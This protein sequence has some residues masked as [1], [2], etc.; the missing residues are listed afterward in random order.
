MSSI[1][2]C[3]RILLW[4][5]FCFIMFVEAQDT[6]RDTQLPVLI[7]PPNQIRNRGSPGCGVIDYFIKVVNATTIHFDTQLDIIG[8]H[9]IS[10]SSMENI[11]SFTLGE[12]AEDSITLTAEYNRKNTTTCTFNFTLTDEYIPQPSRLS[13]PDDQTETRTC[14][15]SDYMFYFEDL[16]LENATINGQTTQI[17]QPIFIGYGKTKLEYIAMDAFGKNHRCSSSVTIKPAIVEFTTGRDNCDA[18]AVCT[19]TEGSFACKCNTGYTGDGRTCTASSEP[20]TESNTKATVTPRVTTT[21]S[22]RERPTTIAIR[23]V[24]TQGVGTAT[25]TMETTRTTAKTRISSTGSTEAMKTTDTTVTTRISSTGSTETTEMTRAAAT[26]RI[27]S[28]EYVGKI[29]DWWVPVQ[30]GLCG[31]VVIMFVIGIIVRFVR[32]KNLANHDGNL[33]M[34]EQ[35]IYIEN[36][37]ET[38]SYSEPL[39]PATYPMT[40]NPIH[41][42]LGTHGDSIPSHPPPSPPT[43]R[44]SPNPGSSLRNHDYEEPHQEP[45]SPPRSPQPQPAANIES[46]FSQMALTGNFTINVENV[47]INTNNQIISYY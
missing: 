16:D 3:N 40:M 21:Q 15:E 38:H 17:I 34:P 11:T 28:T 1:P 7:C 30:I 24:S 22:N 35:S 43:L 46:I 9:N 20:A 23:M 26:T 12:C 25:E 31:S 41:S 8:G 13:C 2:S 19:N 33:D 6:P 29:Y 37:Y 18:N 27:G 14:Y 42:L 45:V 36:S 39:S 47:N 10:V 5:Y 4:I 44:Q 32:K